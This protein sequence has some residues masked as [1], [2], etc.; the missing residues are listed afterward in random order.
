MK[1]MQFHLLLF[2]GLSVVLSSENNLVITKTD[3][4]KQYSP[5]SQIRKLTFSSSGDV[6]Q[7]HLTSGTII[8]DSIKSIQ[9]MFFD[10]SGSVFVASPAF[11]QNPAKFELSQNFP[12]PYNPSTTIR[13]DVGEKQ[14][15]SLKVYN[16][17]GKVVAT[18]VN[19]DLP[20]GQYSATFDAGN[21]SS[22]VYFYKLT[23]GSAS[24]SKKMILTK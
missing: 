6:L 10:T 17:L 19:E 8:S 15:V 14:L 5:I 11:H 24:V 21:M 13:F 9:K 3:G 12:N 22:G 2:F 1:I 4:S 16:V 7:R 23:V 20:A 18:L